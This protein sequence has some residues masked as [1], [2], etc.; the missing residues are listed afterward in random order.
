MSAYVSRKNRGALPA[1]SEVVLQPLRIHDPV[2]QGTEGLFDTSL[3]DLE[4]DFIARLESKLLSD[5]ARD[6]DSE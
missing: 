6:D 2:L 4:D 3:F 1:P 5:V